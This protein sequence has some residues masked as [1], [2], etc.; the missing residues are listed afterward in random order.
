MLEQKSF[1]KI[2]LL[3]FFAIFLTILNLSN[4]KISGFAKIMPLF[5]LMIIFYFT[6]FK[7]RFGLWFVFIL[8]IWNDALNGNLLGL[9]SL[10][11]IVLIKLFTLFNNRA[12]V[13]ESFMQIWQQFIAFCFLFLFI[14]WIIFVIINGKTSSFATLFIQLF[15]SSFFYVL[16]HMFFDYLSKKLL[17]E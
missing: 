8:G 3:Y 16:M 4:I 5:D 9:T 11:Y 6:I 1:T 15:L 7:D 2:I 12:F 10:C 14:K 17:G 13:R